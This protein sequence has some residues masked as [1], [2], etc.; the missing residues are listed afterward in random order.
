MPSSPRVDSQLLGIRERQAGLAARL[1]RLRDRPS[2]DLPGTPVLPQLDSHGFDRPSLERRALGLRPEVAAAGVRIA[3][4]EVLEKLAGKRSKPDFTL[5]LTYTLVD[6]RRDEPGRL[7]PPSGNGDDIFGIQGGLNLP[8]RRGKLRAGLD[9]ARELRFAADEMRRAVQSR[10]VADLD[11]LTDRI[12]LG[13]RQLRL[14]DDVLIVQAEEA[15]DSARAGYVVGTLNALDLLD[16]EHVLFGARTAVARAAAD[17]AIYL[18]RLEG[19]VA[20]P[21]EDPTS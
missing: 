20:G 16:A 2:L 12:P 21:L 4:A 11:E 8:V 15:L 10:I 1:G 7:Q 6:S 18:A 19:V 9:E 5:G 17:Y 3:R 13:W 14:L